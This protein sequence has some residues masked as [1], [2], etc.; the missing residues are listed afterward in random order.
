SGSDR[1]VRRLFGLGGERPR[2]RIAGKDVR[3]LSRPADAIAADIGLVP[4]ER[5]LG[6]VMNLSVRDNILLPSLTRDNHPLWVNTK[7][8]DVV[9]D[10]LMALLDIRPR[11]P[12]LR[13][14]SLSGGNQ[15]K[16]IIAKWLA[17]RV[18]TLLL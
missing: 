12:E 10:E 15:Q 16:V 18:T 11:R 3:R 14:G 17:R 8:G 1:I 4:G 6:L 7:A 2:V 5:A 13:V 9:V